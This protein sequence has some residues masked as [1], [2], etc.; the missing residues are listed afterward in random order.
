MKIIDNFL[1]NYQFTQIKSFLLSD[2][3]PWSYGNGILGDDV[4]PG[5]FQFYRRFFDDGRLAKDD[6]VPLLEPC[7]RGLVG[8]IEP[9]VLHSIFGSGYG[10]ILSIKANLNPKT[11]FHGQL[12]Y[13]TDFKDPS[14]SFKTSV[15]YINTNN[16]WT[17]LKTGEKV[18]SVENRMIIFDSD[19]EH[20]GV[21][22]TDQNRRVIVNF[23][24]ESN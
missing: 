23:N 6:E 9:S 17:E 19:I 2:N 18:K 3:F 21:T 4:P 7:I 20:Q 5:F 22:C 12:G 24:Y 10:K 11:V 14:P 13:H 16:G 1:P 8:E 15:Y